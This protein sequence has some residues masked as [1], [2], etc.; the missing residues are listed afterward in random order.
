[1]FSSLLPNVI[2]P[3]FSLMPHSHTILRAR[4]VARSMS[5]PAPVVTWPSTISSAARP[6]KKIARSFSRRERHL[7]QVHADDALAALDVRPRH[8]HAT[9]EAARAQQRR[10]EHVGTVGGGDQDDAV[11][12][13]EAV[14]LD[15]QLVERLLALVVTAT[16]AG[17]TV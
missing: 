15:Q 8:D 3:S 12:R 14:H 11:V 17:A 1:M 6:P 2:G 4:S 7:A 10:V 16:E 13:F 9:V 5:L